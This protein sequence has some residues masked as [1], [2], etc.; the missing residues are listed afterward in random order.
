VSLAKVNLRTVEL[1]AR[2]DE[3]GF[4]H[5]ATGIGPRLGAWRIGA[6]VYQAEA[7]APIWPYHYHYGVEEWV[8]VL[9]GAPVLREPAGERAL[10]PG[11]VVAFPPGFAGAHTF[12]GPGRFVLFSTGTHV[13]PWLSVHLDSDRVSGPGGILLRS[14][15]VSYW[16]GEGTAGELEPVEFRREP[17]WSPP[18]PA[19]NV[20]SAG[21]GTRLGPLLQAERLDATVVELGSGEAEAYHSTY[22]R[23]QWLVVLA[24]APTVRHPDG[25]ERLEAADVVCFAEG[26]PGAHQVRNDGQETVRSLLLT[27][28]GL[29]ANVHYPESG[30]WR[31]LNG[32]DDVVEL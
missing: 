7:G 1:D 8:Y 29:P 20:L 27:T 24:G 30:R 17:E 6:G 12:R 23:E 19:V 13:E 15:A 3:Y 25:E 9:E 32:P 21:G 11:D 18:Q 5:A 4:R 26:P 2:L 22:G 31:L 28:T 14:A 10:A 16:H